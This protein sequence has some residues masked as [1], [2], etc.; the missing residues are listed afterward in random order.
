MVLGFASG[1]VLGKVDFAACCCYYSTSDFPDYLCL[2]YYCYPSNSGLNCPAI[3]GYY[4]HFDCTLGWGGHR[5][6][7]WMPPCCLLV[8]AAGIHQC[9]GFNQHKFCKFFVELVVGFAAVEFAELVDSTA[10]ASAGWSSHRCF[11]LEQQS[12]C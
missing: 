9:N 8:G 7:E 10:F 3:H 4:F 12:L 5:S 11:E 2:P 6:C 1:E